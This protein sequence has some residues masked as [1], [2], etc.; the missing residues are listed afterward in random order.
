MNK[1]SLFLKIFYYCVM[2]LFLNT[3]A[4]SQ[5]KSNLESLYEQATETSGLVQQYM[6]DSR[7]IDY[8]YGPMGTG[9]RFGGPAVRNPE[10]LQRMI[11][12]DESYLEKLKKVDF[13]RISIY[14]Q[15][16]YIVLKQKIENDLIA[17]RNEE[18]LQKSIAAFI[19]FSD[20]IYLFEK[21][22]R[23]G[24]T[25]D[26]QTIATTL[27]NTLQ[28]VKRSK[29]SLEAGPKIEEQK[30]KYLLN[31]LD[32]IIARLKSSFNFYNTYDPLFTW[33]VPQSYEVLQKE[34]DDFK[35]TAK[36]KSDIKIFNDG[37]NIG[38]NPVGKEELNR[39]LKS[40]MVDYSYEDLLRL[41][42]QEMAWCKQQVMKATKEMGLGTDWKA[43]M[44]KVKNSYVKPGNQP[45]LIVKLYNDAISFIKEKKLIDI[46]P[47]AD[48][49]WGMIM[50]TPQRQLVNPFFT[51]GREISISY[52]TNTMDYDD[53][54]MSMR[55]NNPYF[56]RP[57]VQHELIPG[58]HLQFYMN[59]RYKSY[60][61]AAFNTAFTTEGW[62]LYWEMLL[63]NEGFFKTPEEIL[64]AMF[65]RMH[66]CARITFSIKFHIGEWT[67]Q[68]CV[69]YLV[70]EVGHEYANA[71]AEVK[72]SFEENYGPLYQLAYL[73]GGL[74]LMSIHHELVDSGKMT[75]A[76][77]HDKVIKEN[78][79][80]MEM[81]RA[82]LTGQKLSR[83]F[84]TNWKFYDFKN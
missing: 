81:V 73:I 47:L 58:H 42:D 79:L 55:G 26:G 37:S 33:W 13:D 27:N 15:V 12:L 25:V 36:K 64:G 70:N 10:Q 65:W 49:T 21:N 56:S 57:T 39:L 69:D 45:E 17:L 7:A 71:H 61:Q 82:T 4:L 8:F 52:P 48:E 60:R 6:Q 68:Q 30:A 67:P 80:P 31:T 59:S 40:E 28:I 38:G 19:P 44:E 20:S 35:L 14:G 29:T 53:K 76:V 9:F 77:F 50:M 24:N 41:A 78:H 62:S 54:L 72:R 5:S 75:N 22:R 83:D 66:R 63:F 23:R 32:D 18:N 11:R 51:G 46:P 16:D 43:A 1:G 84:K 3:S 74:Q 34:L 2:V